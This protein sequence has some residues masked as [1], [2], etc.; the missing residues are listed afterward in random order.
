M[1]G[2]GGGVRFLIEIMALGLLAV[3]FSCGLLILVLN[4][5]HG[6]SG[7]RVILRVRTLNSLGRKIRLGNWVIIEES[8]GFANLWT[9]TLLHYL[10]MRW[11]HV[12]R[13]VRGNERKWN[14]FFASTPA[15]RST[16]INQSAC[17]EILGNIF[18][19]GKRAGGNL[20]LYIKR[21]R[22]VL[23]KVGELLLHNKL[24]MVIFDGICSENVGKV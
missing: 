18:W 12:T 24:I 19:R 16:G 23:R 21:R 15:V 20:S 14:T 6:T 4:T 11:R 3:G 10:F 9:M 2:G 13:D 17:M 7:D 8:V 5:V 22:C 1:N